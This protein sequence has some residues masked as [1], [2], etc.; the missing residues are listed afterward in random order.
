MLLR[1]LGPLAA[2]RRSIWLLGC[3]AFRW[4]FTPRRP[5]CWRW[6]GCSRRWHRRRRGRRRGRGRGRGRRRGR[7]WRRGRRCRCRC[8]RATHLSSCQADEVARLFGLIIAAEPKKHASAE[9]IRLAACEEFGC[10]RAVALQERRIWTNADHLEPRVA[11]SLDVA[12][13]S[14]HLLVALDHVIAAHVDASRQW[15]RFA[16]RRLR[17][18]RGEDLDVE[19]RCLPP[20]ARGFLEAERALRVNMHGDGALSIGP[21]RDRGA[22]AAASAGPPFLCI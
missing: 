13:R 20:G 11:S 18:W 21:S 4:R 6:H 15:Q 10:A 16:A 1:G 14:R 8:A 9:L 2:L 7:G 19:H 12:L 3:R 22:V 5:T 17:V